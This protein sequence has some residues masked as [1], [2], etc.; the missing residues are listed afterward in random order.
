MKRCTKC[1]TWRQK[2][3][4]TLLTTQCVQKYQDTCRRR[5]V[6]WPERRQKLLE[7]KAQQA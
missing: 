5:A 1:G 7:R 6:T 3:A 4:L 2:G